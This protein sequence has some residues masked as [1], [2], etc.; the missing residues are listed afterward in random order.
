MGF[1]LLIITKFMTIP[2]GRSKV[3]FW[4]FFFSFNLFIYERRYVRRERKRNGNQYKG[5]AN[6]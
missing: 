5:A 2:R 6:S 1:Q 3:C 4:F